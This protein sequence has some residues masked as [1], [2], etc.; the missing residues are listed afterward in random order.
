MSA[1]GRHLLVAVPGLC[2]PAS[3]PPVSD[4]LQD[5][6][7][8][9]LDRLLSR[10]R[11]HQTSAHGLD[12]TLGGFFGLPVAADG[13]MSVAPFT[14]LADT[15]EPAAAAWL[16]RADPVHLR[17]DQSCLRLFDCHSFGITREEADALVAAFNTHFRDRGYEL[18][19]PRPQRWYLSLPQPP[20]LQTLSPDRVAGQDIDPCLPRGKDAADWHALLNEVQ[21]LFHSHP[22]NAAREQRGM[23]PINSIWPWGGG[24]LPGPLQPRV[25]RLLA[26]HPLATG[27]ALHTSIPAAGMPVTA[28]AVLA[29]PGDG[30]TLL[31]DDRLEW[32]T[33]YG[34]I[35]AWLEGLQGLETDWL[36]PL[37]AALQNGMLASLEIH[38]CNG[39][40]FVVTRSDLRRFWR[41][42]QAFEIACTDR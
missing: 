26:V 2:G 40:A 6:R 24:R 18:A 4:Y 7:P 17:A 31:V 19:A 15:G 42:V 34:D 16:M 10:A 14:W 39:R 32:P 28:D 11:L 9:A 1:R 30:C 38:P 41:R 20:A 23:P 25:T 5:S 22:V 3:D 29:G 8:A 13:E 12:A 36:A 37:Q 33:H 35:E 21:M 27:L